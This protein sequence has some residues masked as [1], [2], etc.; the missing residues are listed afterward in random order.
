MTYTSGSV[1]HF[2]MSD[3]MI[4]RDDGEAFVRDE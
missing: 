1:Y 2:G 3:D 4:N